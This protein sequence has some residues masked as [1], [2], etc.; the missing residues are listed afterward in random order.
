[1]LDQWLDM[2]LNDKAPPVYSGALASASYRLHAPGVLELVPDTRATNARACVFSAAVHGNETAPV[3]LIGEL[4]AAIEA[5]TLR[6]GAPLLVMLGNIPAL[7]A[8]T[9]Y[10]TTNLNRLFKRGLDTAGSEPDRA[11][12]LIARVDAFYARHSAL[13]PLHYDLH[14]AIRES[15]YPRFA[16]VPYSSTPTAPEQWEWLAA[17]GIQAVLDQHCHSWTLSHYSRHY[18]GAQA[19]TLE[20]GRV[21]PFGGNDLAA[22]GP[23]LGL[24][25]ALAG[26]AI[27]ARAPADTMDFFRVER[28]VR[29]ESDEFC[30]CF[31]D[32]TPNFTAFAPGTRLARDARTGDTVVDHTPLHVVFPNARVEIGAR[33]ALLATAAAPP[34]TKVE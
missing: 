7:R 20:L 28:E 13:P 27:P 32:D 8:G 30:L 18:H 33:A 25:K 22:L 6:L 12:E 11:R 24:L 2:T 26:G 34:N 31:A 21:A 23:M 15:L 10:I 16:V 5:G 14:T 4:L 9:R 3:E 17:A 19:F 29:R 1:M